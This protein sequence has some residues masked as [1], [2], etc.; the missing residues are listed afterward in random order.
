MTVIVSFNKNEQQRDA[1][2]NAAIDPVDEDDL[3]YLRRDYLDEAETDLSRF[4]SCW[5]IMMAVNTKI[6]VFWPETPCVYV[7]KCQRLEEIYQT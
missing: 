4:N 1:K 3:E 6:A 5:M 2:S 7:D